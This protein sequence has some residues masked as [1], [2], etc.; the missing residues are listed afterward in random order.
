LA[1]LKKLTESFQNHID[2]LYGC[3]ARLELQL[4]NRKV[5]ITDV[6]LLYS[7]AFLSACARWE[8]FLEGSLIEASCGQASSLKGNYRHAEFRSR[9]V[10]RNLL[11]FP[12]KDYISL[13]SV[14]HATAMASLLINEGR[15]FS[16]ISEPNRTYIQQA[17]WIRN[18]I[19]HQSDF[20]LR[21][22]RDK[23]PGVSS[24]PRNRRL[25]GTFLRREFRTSPSQRR[26]EIYFTAF[27]S[28]AAEILDS[29]C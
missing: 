12:D 8:G 27:K 15:P 21:I 1:H 22:F 29:W 25:P 5:S 19:A 13:P 4:V 23:V 20:S 18:A 24:L 10:L 2:T 11:L 9:S 6:E 14:K 3:V 7:S 16:Q 17:G 28:A 26:F